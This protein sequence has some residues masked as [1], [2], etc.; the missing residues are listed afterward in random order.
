[1]GQGGAAW[2]LGGFSGFAIV[3]GGGVL[4]AAAFGG[5]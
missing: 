2:L 4:L 1:M 3:R 5:W